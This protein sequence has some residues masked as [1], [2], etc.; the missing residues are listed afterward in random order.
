M[1]AKQFQ[2]IQDKADAKMK[3]MAKTNSE[4]NKKQA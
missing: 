2:R 3:A 4:K 1:K